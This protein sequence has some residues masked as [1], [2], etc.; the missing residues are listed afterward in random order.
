MKN[1]N[2]IPLFP[3]NIVLFPGG[4]FDLQIFE[5][6][7]IDLVSHCMRTGTGFGICLLKSGD[8]TNG[9]NLNQTVY[10]TGTYAKIVDWDQ[11]ESGLLGITVEGAV[12][13]VAQ[14]FW[15]EEDDVLHASVEFSDIESTEADVIP[16]GDEYT[17]LSELLR[18]LEDHPLVA[19]R[20]LSIDYSDLRQLGWRLS[21]LIPLGI[22]VRQ[23]LLELNDPVERLSKIEKL[24]S[25]MANNS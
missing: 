21:E 20:N 12:K 23:E 8:E 2:D 5:R 14:D 13:F 3:L 7:Y 25:E 11:L 16:L 9:N 22:D 17:A 24:V 1:T 19:G 6:R 18:N 4:R 15:K 10:N